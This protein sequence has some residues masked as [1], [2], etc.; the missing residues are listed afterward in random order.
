M[1]GSQAARDPRLWVRRIAWLV[2]IWAL[3]VGAVALVALLLKAIMRLV[4]MTA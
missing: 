4:G 1:P 2:A 3:S